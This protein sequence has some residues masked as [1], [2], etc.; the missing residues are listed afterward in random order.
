M[1]SSWGPPSHNFVAEY[2]QSSI[3]FVTSSAT[4]EVGG[5]NP[6]RV[7]F[8]Y[9][10]RWVVIHN[11][12]KTQ[13]D[14]IRFGFSSNGVMGTSGRN[15]FEIDGSET[16]MRLEVKCREIWFLADDGSKP[17]GFTVL[18]GLTN[19][20]SKDFPVLTGSNGIAGVG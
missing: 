9:V 1:S 3:P 5:T 7:S 2:Q 16:T 8:P 10:T 18:A 20:P 19:V 13:T 11:K 6:V 4:N 12:N 17:C 15:Y 14:T